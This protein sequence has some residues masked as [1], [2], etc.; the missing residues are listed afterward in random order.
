M[1]HSIGYTKGQQNS[2]STKTQSHLTLFVPGKHHLSI[3]KLC[4]DFVSKTTQ[5]ATA[6]AQ[7]KAASVNV[8]NKLCSGFI[9]RLLVTS[10]HLKG[11]I[12][13]LFRILPLSRP[14]KYRVSSRLY[15]SITVYP[16]IFSLA[17]FPKC[18]EKGKHQASQ[19]Q[20][21]HGSW[22]QRGS[23]MIYLMHQ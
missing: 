6:S 14:L 5:I 22:S 12:M 1:S 17:L 7:K 4:S 10:S 8:R 18:R 21:D 2:V 19:E 16:F 3:C 15:A 23:A 20:W 13:I 11:M 9:Q